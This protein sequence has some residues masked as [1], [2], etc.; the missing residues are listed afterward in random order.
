MYLNLAAFKIKLATLP[1]IE[2]AKQTKIEE[3]MPSN[4]V[5]HRISFS[6]IV[7]VMFSSLGWTR[8]HIHTYILT[9]IYIY[10]YIYNRFIQSPLL[11]WIYYT[12]HDNMTFGDCNIVLFTLNETQQFIQHPSNMTIIIII[13]NIMI[14]MTVMF[15]IMFIIIL[16][17]VII[18]TTIAS[19]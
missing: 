15:F 12:C 14:I 3:K 9:F 10:E 7:C 18:N 6:A 1:R 11:K 2:L 17:I 5:K 16:I 4:Q 19:K 8:S 13:T